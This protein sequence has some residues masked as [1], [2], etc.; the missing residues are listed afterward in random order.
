MALSL[1][2]PTAYG[3]NG[4]TVAGVSP[5]AIQMFLVI[6]SLRQEL[7]KPLRFNFARAL[8]H[9]YDGRKERNKTITGPGSSSKIIQWLYSTSVQYKQAQ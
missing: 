1:S 3:T 8:R 2:P 5:G 4:H 6:T 7:L 9:S